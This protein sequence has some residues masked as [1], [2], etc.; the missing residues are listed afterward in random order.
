MS[1][2]NHIWISVGCPPQMLLINTS[3]RN[4]NMPNKLTGN[5][6]LEGITNVFED[7]FKTQKDQQ[8]GTMKFI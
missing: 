6:E 5:T 4:I 2:T 1:Q 7:E 8:D 3:D